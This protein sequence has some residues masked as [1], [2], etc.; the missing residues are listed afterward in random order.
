LNE[1]FYLFCSTHIKFQY[2]TR[3]T[4]CGVLAFLIVYAIALCHCFIRKKNTLNAILLVLFTATLSFA[5][6]VVSLE[7]KYDIFLNAAG[8]LAT[9]CFVLTIA[10]SQ[11]KVL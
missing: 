10:T 11:T 5:T 4:V 8:A 2:D 3:M 7:V 6:T 1:I 9:N